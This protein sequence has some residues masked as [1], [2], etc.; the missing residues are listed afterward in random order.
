MDTKE[1]TVKGTIWSMVERFSTMGIQ[2]LC[3]LVIAQFLPPSLFGIISMMSIFL[4]FSMVMAEGGFGQAIIRE[5]NVSQIDTSSIFY[6]NIILGV[7][8]YFISFFS[9]PLIADFYR[10]PQ[11]ILLVRVSF[12]A[13][14]INSFTIVQEAQLYKSVNFA[15]VSKVS[16]ISVLLSGILGII[17]AVLQKDVWSLIIQ[18][19]SY[20]VI[21]TFL[22][23]YLNDWRPKAVYSWQSVKK[24][25]SFSI[26]LL[27]SRMIASLAD[28]A[29]NLFIGR[30]YSSTE[31]GNYTVP[32][33]LQRSVAGTISFAIHRVSYPI[34][35]TFQDDKK[36]LKEYS[37]KVV[38]TAFFIISPIMIFF[39]IESKQFFS[40][41]LSPQWAE[42]AIY[43][44][45]MC[46]IG[47][48]FCFA[49]INMDILLVKGKSRLVLILEI[50]RKSVLVVSLL[51]GIN[52]SIHILLFVLVTYNIFNT[53]LVSYY[54]GKEI[55]CSLFQQF[56]N[57]LPI[58]LI[59]CISGITTFFV[60]NVIANN[61]ENLFCS[62]IVFFIMF[63]GLSKLF[64]L[65]TFFFIQSLIIQTLN[66]KKQLL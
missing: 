45:Y 14:I 51:I 64:K 38:N 19:I 20:A 60:S 1:T 9:A 46:I 63:I 31:L 27:I 10:Q 2:L 62:F 61:I 16:L 48:L 43:F 15:L 50:V 24:Y 22:Y 40:I 41:I 17:I 29:A 32:D 35:A 36:K 57:I 18:S 58:L 55:S 49:D 30:A 11:L 65:S 13:I 21:R 56:K 37:Q 3:T 28:N 12:I 66:K 23:W 8:I 26:N 59:L 33:K 53:I 42:S 6:F 7:I 39:M 5:K 25:L 52:Y 34:M 44:K 54:S 4:S 47:A